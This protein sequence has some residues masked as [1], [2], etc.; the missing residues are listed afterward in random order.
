MINLIHCCVNFME[1]QL[2]MTIIK[3]SCGLLRTI[4]RNFGRLLD[5]IRASIVT[6]STMVVLSVE[7]LMCE[8]K[9]IKNVSCI[10]LPHNRVTFNPNFVIIVSNLLE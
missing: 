10:I 2:K 3:W 1:L 9:T 7:N 5:G 4:E 8:T 6:N